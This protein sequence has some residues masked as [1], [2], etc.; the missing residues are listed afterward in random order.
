M[1]HPHF[2]HL[3]AAILVA[4]F[5]YA[6]A[7]YLVLPAA[8]PVTVLQSQE[9]TA[10]AAVTPLQDSDLA[11]RINGEELT[12]EKLK[13]LLNLRPDQNNPVH[14]ENDLPVL[15]GEA[16]EQVARQI[17]AYDLLAAEALAAGVTLTEAKL[18]EAAQVADRY[19]GSVL[20]REVVLD[21]IVKP[22]DEQLMARYEEVKGEKYRQE[23][24]LRMRQIFVSTYKPYTV[25]EGDTLE[26]IALAVNGD[27]SIASAIL[28]DKTKKP[29]A[30]EF[31]AVEGS[32][33]ETLPPRALLAGELLLVPMGEA[34]AAAA[35]A[36]ATSAHTALKEGQGFVAVANEFSENARPG[37]LWVIRPA[38][39]ERPVLAEILE[40]FHSLEDGAFSEPIRTKHGWHIILREAYVPA[41][42]RPFDEV[43]NLILSD[44][45]GEQRQKLTDEFFTK[46]IDMDGAVVI[47]EENVAKGDDRLSP[48][49]VVVTVAGREFKREEFNA[50]TRNLLDDPDRRTAEEIKKAI[51]STGIFQASLVRYFR[52]NSE[53]ATRPM[54][55]F[56]NNAVKQ[57]QLAQV[58]VQNRLEVEVPEPSEE[59]ILAFYNENAARFTIPEQYEFVSFTLREPAGSEPGAIQVMQAEL[60]ESLGAV[61][62]L[63]DFL[64][65]AA[66]YRSRPEGSG[67]SKELRPAKIARNQLREVVI[68][69]LAAAQRPG[70]APVVQD[71]NAL[72]AYWVVGYEAER[73]QPLDEL[74]ARIAQ[75]LRQAKQR[76][77]QEEI[78]NSYLAKVEVELL[79][80]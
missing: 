19:A 7:T 5:T 9:E 30:E 23:E 66:E 48:D 17:G 49:D 36:K 58:F 72:N 69:A 20:Y 16:L 32:T 70:V 31:D 42:F 11:V 73:L 55:Q 62:S 59:E 37:E 6:P 38:R 79:A 46:V 54:T 65:L 56:F 3:T 24:E 1:R 4:A 21:R 67:I 51:R 61:R 39:Q 18:E 26:S 29:R 60:Q 27:E 15:R 75:Q 52:E 77:L 53:Y 80:E 40:T 35:L 76:E 12:L 50:M 10:P 78:F 71:G 8:E 47:S 13:V 22:T 68:N 28:S 25:A 34:D 41:G 74:R 57:T 64:Q 43:R 44:L 2:R 45:E 33:G 14:P 63:E